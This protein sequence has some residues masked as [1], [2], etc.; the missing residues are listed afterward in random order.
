MKKFLVLFLVSIFVLSFLSTACT[1]KPSAAGPSDVSPTMTPTQTATPNINFVIY[2]YN[3]GAAVGALNMQMTNGVVNTLVQATDLLGKTSFTLHNN[4]TWT[5]MVPAQGGWN[6]Q[7]YT[8]NNV[9]A[10]S[11]STFAF[12]IGHQTLDIDLMSGS[13]TVNMAA[14]IITYK[15]TYHTGASKLFNLTIAN[16][17]S[18]V[19][20]TIDNSQVSNDG[21][22][23]T[24]TLTIPKSFEN[25]PVAD[26][27]FIW[28]MAGTDTTTLHLPITVNNTRTVTKNWNFLVNASIILQKMADTNTLT[29]HIALNSVV[30]SAQGTAMTVGT[31]NKSVVNA[32]LVG[33]DV[34]N[35]LQ[36]LVST[37]PGDMGHGTGNPDIFCRIDSGYTNDNMAKDYVYGHNNL[38]GNVTLHFTDSNNLDIYR[39]FTTTGL[40]QGW[41]QACGNFTQW[42]YLLNGSQFDS[43]GNYPNTT[44]CSYQ[45]W[46]AYRS[47]TQNVQGTK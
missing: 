35:P 27:S 40:D 21:D 23:R 18:G 6:M 46:Y 26:T 45:N 4:G 13:E 29:Y 22:I 2:A 31:I 25:Y 1:R 8:I 5:I 3:N 19:T 43:C 42:C 39:T 44:G 14:Q 10:I 12:D 17:P 38:D 34:A 32:W 24:V 16:I 47:K 15:V 36:A 41:S 28:T 7:A 11:N 30:L 9:D 37:M 20:G 33:S